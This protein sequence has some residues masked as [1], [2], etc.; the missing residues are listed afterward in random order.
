MVALLWLG[1]PAMAGSAS[2]GL[3]IG[4]RRREE[5]S[6]QIALMT[7][8]Y[9]VKGYAAPEAKVAVERARSL[10]A[11]AESLGE[12]LENPLAIFA[13]LDGIWT[14][15][16]FAFNGDALTEL[17]AQFFAL[18]EKQDNKNVLLTVNLDAALALTTMGSPDGALTHF[19]RAMA[20]Y[21][22]ADAHPLIAL[23]G[24][25]YR[26]PGLVMR[27]ICLWLLGY[28]DAAVSESERAVD[29]ARACGHAVTLLMT[30]SQSAIIQNLCGRTQ[31]ATA[32]ADE[33]E[34]QSNE[35][36]LALFLLMATMVRAGVAA[37][38]GD[39]SSAVQTILSAAGLLRQTGT[40]LF[41]PTHEM[42]LATAYARLG[43]LDFA[44]ESIREALEHIQ[45]SK[46]TWFE[47]DVHR[48][49]G[50]IAL[51]S[52]EQDAAGAQAHFERAIDVARL[53][54]ARSLELRAAT[55]LARLWRDQGK[56]HEARELLAPVYGWFTEGFDTRDLLEAKALLDEFAS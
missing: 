8:L 40:T 36:E 56:R 6:L 7:S 23:T 1:S 20:L 44:R 35:K 48:A 33:V 28:P 25:D 17:T 3:R 41:A 49:A 30:L 43:Q 50:E 26:Y 5:I 47:A 55:S 42:L 11:Q 18:A 34:A 16:Y 39:A 32:L 31:A 13:I 24:F 46:E 22:E 27:A 4:R 14:V 53:Q 54:K 52:P 10:F 45:T 38:V 37:Q 9:S 21:S 29:G 12:P 15:N 19:D 2:F 51:M